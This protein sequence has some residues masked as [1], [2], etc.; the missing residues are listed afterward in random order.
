MM[1]AMDKMERSMRVDSLP[2]RR[3][4][5]SLVGPGIAVS[6]SGISGGPGDEVVAA[7]MLERTARVMNSYCGGD[8]ALGRRGGDGVWKL[9][10]CDASQDVANEAQSVPNEDVSESRKRRAVRAEA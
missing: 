2:K 10:R 5:L 9:R 3:P 4:S 7:L 1:G 6:N 8:R